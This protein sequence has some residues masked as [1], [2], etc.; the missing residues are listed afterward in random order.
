MR[1]ANDASAVVFLLAGT[2]RAHDA[3]AVVL[4]AMGETQRIIHSGK[5]HAQANP[6]PAISS[7]LADSIHDFQNA[8]QEE[9]SINA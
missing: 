4:R 7:Q 9:L 2:T 5:S 3:C 6:W 8:A 1:S